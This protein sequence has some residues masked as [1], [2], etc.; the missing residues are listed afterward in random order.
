M[1]LVQKMQ[2]NNE[3]EKRDQRTERENINIHYFL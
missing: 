1:S 2:E 3:K